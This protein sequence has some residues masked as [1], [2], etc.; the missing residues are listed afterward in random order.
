MKNVLITGGSGLIGKNLIKR[1]QAE[2]HQVSILS[3]NPE[4]VKGV[5][6]FYWNPQK[7]EI[8]RYCLL[9][10]NTII[11]LAGE[12]IADKRWTR[13]RKR[14]IIDSRTLSIALLYKVLHETKMSVDSVISASAVGYYGDR[15]EEL[16][17]ED[18]NKGAG[19]LADCCQ[20]WEEAVDKGTELGFRVVKFRIGLLLSK[21]GGALMEFQK[22][23]RNYM[24]SDL[25][26]GRQWYPWIHI[27]DLV[28][29][30]A[31][32]VDDSTYQGTYNACSPSPVRNHEFTKEVAK[33]IHR[34]LW[35]IKINKV[36]LNIVLGE[37]SSLVLMSTNTSSKKIENQ[38]Y[39]FKYTTI[40][41]A[42]YS[43]F[44]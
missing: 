18:S 6:A 39:S 9:G 20:E 32:A 10:I 21:D 7:Q 28:E 26:S 12:G 33:T 31:K 30:F 13:A 15:G 35:P 41:D 17:T 16:L 36:I 38:G 11:H 34:P 3:R 24:G 37:K 42:L 29:M 25:G 2:G 27:D 22:I 23:V 8:D 19:F 40:R 14:E 5:K 44:S 43:I 4:D 1:L